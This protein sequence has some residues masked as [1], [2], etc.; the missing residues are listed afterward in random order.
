MFESQ[1]MSQKQLV[2]CLGESLDIFVE[3]MGVWE[4]SSWGKMEGKVA[5]IERP[6]TQ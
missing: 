6:A 3:C 4:S 1:T 5:G 2:S